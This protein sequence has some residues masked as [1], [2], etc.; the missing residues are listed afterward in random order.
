MKIILRFL[1]VFVFLS[2][3]VM[4]SCKKSDQAS[5]A[6]NPFSNG[7]SERNMI[8]IM[9][10]MHIGVDTSYSEC[11]KNRGP[12]IKI[13]K[14]IQAS[15]NVRELVIAG[16]LVDEWFV[17]ADVD[18]YQGN[19]QADF[20]Q[21]LAT[22]NKEVFDEINNI[23]QEGKI[24]VTYLPGNHDLTITAAS[25]EIILPGVNQARDNVL[26]LG[27]YSPA[28]CPQIA[29]EHSHRYN[30]FCAPDPNSNQDIAPGTI[31]PPGYFFTRIAALFVQQQK[32]H[33]PP[34]PVDSL[35]IITLN[36]SSDESQILLFKYWKTWYETMHMFA[37]N[38]KFDEKIIVTNMNGFTDNYSVDELV[39]FQSSP[40]GYIDVDLYKG[41]QEKWTDRE[42]HN[43]VAV[44]I[45]TEYAVDSVMSN[46]F[47]DHQANQQYFLNAAS[48]KRIVVFGHT[49]VP[50]IDA[51][52]SH[53]GKKCIYANSGT[54]IDNNTNALTTMNFVV[55][56]PQ[57]ADA[58]S[59]TQVKLYNFENEVV[60]LMGEDAVRY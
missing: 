2:L 48:D 24:L 44:H 19:D 27:T 37:I 7:G 12:L 42:N 54:W 59:Q 38:N 50:R 5:S 20:V 31:M 34:P 1:I 30:F 3:F 57:N 53:D 25:I 4:T 52:I 40:D 8:V 23:I 46:T 18:T 51:G 28:D 15:P 58:S 55:I 60:T 14:Q 22:T 45:K 32:Q 29:I 17:P 13:L 35:P 41:I 26:G 39:P 6:I 33:N 21:R 10:D 9:S 47:T 49:H 56:T 11:V 36:S 16:D 43:H